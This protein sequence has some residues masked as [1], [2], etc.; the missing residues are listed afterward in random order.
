MQAKLKAGPDFP[1]MKIVKKELKKEK[2][3]ENK[4]EEKK[5]DEEQ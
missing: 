4:V 3:E 1:N 5:P 2:V